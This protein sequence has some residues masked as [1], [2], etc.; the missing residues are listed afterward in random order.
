M[1]GRSF[2]VIML[3]ISERKGCVLVR[4]RVRPRASA[5]SVAGAHA[6]AL[7]ILVTAPPERGKANRAARDLL[8]ERL[9]LPRS[10][11]E[12]V[13]GGGSRDKLFVIKGLRSVEVRRRLERD[14]R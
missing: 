3:D 8:A 1:R 5:N 9:G 13:R 10:S 11:L 4:V 2:E 14:L 6:G 7:K 12:I